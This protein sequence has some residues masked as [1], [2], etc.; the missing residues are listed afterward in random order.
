MMKLANLG[1]RWLAL[2]GGVVLCALTVMVVVSVSMRALGAAGLKPVPGDFELVEMGTAVAVF[3]FLPWCYLRNG[4]AMVDLLYMHL[5]V[6][7][8]RTV[9]VLSDVL[10]LAIWVVLTWRLGI[11]VADKF[12]EHETTFIL[13]VPL[14]IPQAIGLVG[15]TVG[16]LVYLAKTLAEIGWVSAD[17]GG[18]GGGASTAGGHA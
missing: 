8:Q 15:A 2:A 18:H 13:Q 10:M 5:P 12:G 1:A 14:W 6:P 4:H 11:A 16:C 7:V 17:D 9:S 3:F